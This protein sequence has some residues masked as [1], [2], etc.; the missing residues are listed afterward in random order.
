MLAG[1]ADLVIILTSESGSERFG[2]PCA[3][4]C[5]LA[6]DQKVRHHPSIHT[7]FAVDTCRPRFDLAEFELIPETVLRKLASIP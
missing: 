1:L 6:V 7:L 3:R 2:P 5:A 4:S